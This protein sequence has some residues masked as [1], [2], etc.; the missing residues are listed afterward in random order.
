M[1]QMILFLFMISSILTRKTRNLPIFLKKNYKNQDDFIFYD[2][3]TIATAEVKETPEYDYSMNLNSQSEGKRANNLLDK[4][5]ELFLHK[6]TS[7][8]FDEIKLEIKPFYTKLRK[9]NGKKY[10]VNIDKSLKSLL[11]SN[12]Q[13]KYLNDKWSFNGNIL[14]LYHLNK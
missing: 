10:N 7:L 5:I 8:C 3:Y 1:H 11:V 9:S 2:L 12:K 13:F 6:R 14:N 4:V